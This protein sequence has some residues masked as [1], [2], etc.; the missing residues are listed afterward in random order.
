MPNE[1]LIPSNPMMPIEFV[2]AFI[3][4]SALRGIPVDLVLQAEEVDLKNEPGL[5]LDKLVHLIQSLIDRS[6][7]NT[8]FPIMQIVNDEAIS[9]TSMVCTTARTVTEGVRYLME[10]GPYSAI[11]LHVSYQQETDCD[12]FVSESNLPAGLVRTFLIEFSAAFC[13]R[14]IPAQFQASEVL[15]QVEFDFES[16][17]HDEEYERFFSCPVLFSQP[18]NRMKFVKGFAAAD[19]RSHSP[20]LLKSAIDSLK[21]KT[22]KLLSLQGFRFQVAQIIRILLSHKIDAVYSASSQNMELDLSIDKVAQ[23][24]GLSVRSLQRKLKQE[25]SAFTDIKYQ[26]LIEESK[27]WINKGEDNLDFIAE[28]LSF[29][30][31]ASFSKVFKKYEGMWPA[32]YK[33]SV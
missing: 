3:R 18:R 32:Q 31:R 1:V 25:Q 9:D 14:L 29:S 6:T 33:Q 11:G 30:D 24:L 21:Q 12:Y 5:P 15:L 22:I 17:G 20:K 2:H 10:Y 16:N 28:C 27:L 26:T 8:F 7:M 4:A 13:L 19:L 23:E